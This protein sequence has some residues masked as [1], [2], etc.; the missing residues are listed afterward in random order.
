M[1]G[2]VDESSF[3]IFIVVSAACLE[4][5]A[6]WPILTARDSTSG[7]TL[8]LAADLRSGEPC[9]LLS[10]GAG[11]KTSPISID[12][13]QPHLIIIR[14]DRHL[15]RWWLDGD[16]LDAIP[17]S[18]FFVD[19]ASDDDETSTAIATTAQQQAFAIKFDSILLGRS[20]VELEGA[21]PGAHR[22]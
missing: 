11:S 2:E 10:F 7:F 5:T 21:I 12:L 20:V 14:K 6:P 18:S 17:A 4:G 19:E 22:D 16:E 3:T 8:H 15:V 1:S 13:W 9:Y